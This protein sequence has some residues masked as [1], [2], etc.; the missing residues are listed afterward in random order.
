M[1][2]QERRWDRPASERPGRCCSAAAAQGR[3][4]ALSSAA[5]QR[6]ERRLPGS[7]N[8][9]SSVDDGSHPSTH[10]LKLHGI[11]TTMLELAHSHTN[12]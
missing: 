8:P 3:T 7:R 11:F 2:V 5:R 6:T 4:S 1:V 12:Y 9:A 10:G